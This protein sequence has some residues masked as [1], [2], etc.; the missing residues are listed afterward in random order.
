M[1]QPRDRITTDD[2]E[3]GSVTSTKLAAG[4]AAS[5]AAQTYASPVNESDNVSL[6]APFP[7]IGR[8]FVTLA[9]GNANWTGLAGGTDGLTIILKNIDPTNTLV[10]NSE[11]VNSLAANRFNGVGDQTIP[12]GNSAM[13]VYTA[14]TRNRWDIH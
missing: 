4:A 3:D 5:T 10:L 12:P 13:L 7:A 6:P 9:A 1:R 14:G 11:N 8:L 2:L